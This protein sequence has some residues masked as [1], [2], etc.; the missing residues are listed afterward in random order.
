[1]RWTCRDYGDRRPRTR[2]LRAC[3]WPGLAWWASLPAAAHTARLIARQMKNGGLDGRRFSWAVS[4][5]AACGLPSAPRVATC[6]HRFFKPS[7]SMM[8]RRWLRTVFRQA[9]S[10]AMASLEWPSFTWS[11]ISIS[12]AVSAAKRVGVEFAARHLL[13]DGE[14]EA[15]LGRQRTL[16][17]GGQYALVGL[18]RFD[19]VAVDAGMENGLGNFL[20]GVGDGEHDDLDAEVAQFGHEDRGRRRRAANDQAG[21]RP[22]GCRRRASARLSSISESGISAR[23]GSCWM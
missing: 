5:N 4:L 13:H 1:M 2:S 11:T 23:S 16:A 17:D 9:R 22:R 15:A 14:R 3:C 7:F 20:V 19:D 8:L 10:S 21:Q 12:R 18:A 6:T